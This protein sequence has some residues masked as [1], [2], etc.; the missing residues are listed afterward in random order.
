[1][2]SRYYILGDPRYSLHTT[3]K[4]FEKAESSHKTLKPQYQHAYSPQCPQYISNGASWEKL[5]KHQD[6]VYFW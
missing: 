6:I 5:V 1:M 2:V 3:T 4:H